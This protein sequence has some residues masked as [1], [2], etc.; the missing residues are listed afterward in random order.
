MGAAK[1]S[2]D[3]LLEAGLVLASELSLPS[4]LQP[5]VDLATDIAGARYGALGV[6][7]P[8]AGSPSSSRQ[9]W[10]R[11]SASGSGPCRTA[12]GSWGR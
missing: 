7:G 2:T 3:R 12:G 4:V 5:I 8:G 1:A 10:S 9:A 11:R 6:L